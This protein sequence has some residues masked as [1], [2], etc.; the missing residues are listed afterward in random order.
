MSKG[1]SILKISGFVMIF[2]AI[3]GFVVFALNGLSVLTLLNKMKHR[4]DELASNLSSFQS[5]VGFIVVGLV[6]F[7]SVALLVCAL[8]SLNTY[9]Y[10][11]IPGG[12]KKYLVPSRIVLILGGITFLTAVVLL[13]FVSNLG[14]TVLMLIPSG[15][16]VLALLNLIIVKKDREER[17]K[18]APKKAWQF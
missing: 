10:Y 14:F 4:T 13:F 6:L 12:N 17:A 9:N 5:I 1:P 7:T 15:G 8:K 16:W 3:I 18:E 2:Q 11:T